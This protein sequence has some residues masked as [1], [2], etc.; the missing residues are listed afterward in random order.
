MW[1][2]QKKSLLNQEKLKDILKLSNVSKIFEDKTLYKDVNLA[3]HS[4]SKICIVGE[5]GSGK[6]TLLRIMLGQEEPT[7]GEV[8][9]NE[10]AKITYVHQKHILKMKN[11]CIW[12]SKWKIGLSPD[13]IETAIDSLFNH[14]K[15]FRDK[16]ILCF[17]V[18]EKD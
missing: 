16:R 11:F 8:F 9:I 10:T 6:S 5:N 17:L 15:E 1:H 18:G 12:L 14:E 7:S 3:I 2:L 4:D 13:F